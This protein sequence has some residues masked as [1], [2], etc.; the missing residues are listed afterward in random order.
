M[1]NVVIEIDESNHYNPDGT[2]KEKDVQ[3]Q[4]E[5]ENFLKC[6]FIRIKI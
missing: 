5:I 6:K 1:V 2:L 4:K 3:R